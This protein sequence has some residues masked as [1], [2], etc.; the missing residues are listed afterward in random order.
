MP[1]AFI[2]YRASDGIKTKLMHWLDEVHAQTNVRGKLFVRNDQH[3]TT[4]M[5]TYANISSATTQHIEQLAANNP[6]FENIDR[7]CES[8]V[9]ISKRNVE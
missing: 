1:D 5:E 7:R 3:A 4:F 2:W 6:L 9:E 8:F